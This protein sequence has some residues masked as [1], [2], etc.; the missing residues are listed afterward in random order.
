MRARLASLQAQSQAASDAARAAQLRLIQE[1]SDPKALRDAADARNRFEVLTDAVA[2][3][4]R[5]VLH[6][7]REQV[8]EQRAERRA[9]VLARVAQLVQAEEADERELF[10]TVAALYSHTEAELTRIAGLFHAS[11]RRQDALLDAARQLGREV[12]AT[13]THAGESVSTAKLAQQS[14]QGAL[15][16]A[17]EA[18]PNGAVYAV[19]FRTILNDVL[20]QAGR[21]R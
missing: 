20:H 6:A 2:E 15:L 7:E 4:E 18:G 10:E 8:E 5:Q 12:P 17:F 1:A 19:P 16:A 9:E 3:L 13:F 21:S 11:V 14:R